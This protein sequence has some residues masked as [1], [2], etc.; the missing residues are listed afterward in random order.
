MD[1]LIDKDSQLLE[2]KPD[3]SQIHAG[4]IISFE[5]DSMIVVH[6]VVETGYDSIGWYAITQG[7]HNKE[8]DSGLRRANDIKGVVVG[9][10]Y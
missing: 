10:L 2:I 5:M 9:V 7:I 4:D 8:I 6:E 3:I 1:P